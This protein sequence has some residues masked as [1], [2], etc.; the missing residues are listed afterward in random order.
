MADD[1]F[2]GALALAGDGNTALVGAFMATVNAKNDQG[3]AYVF[4]RNGEQWT[5]QQVSQ[6]PPKKNAGLTP[7]CLVTC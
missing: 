4:V 6:P 1:S 5:Q 7:A 2:G 3:T